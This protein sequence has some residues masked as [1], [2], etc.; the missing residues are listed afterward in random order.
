MF[1][2]GRPVRL[3]PVRLL[4]VAVG[5]ALLAGG[6]AG[7]PWSGPPPSTVSRNAPAGAPAACSPTVTISGFSDQL[8]KTEFDGRFV[9]N[10][11]GLAVDTDGN[12][13]A[14]SDRSLLFTLDARTHRPI[15]VRPLADEHGDQLDSEAVLV[16]RDGSRLITSEIEPSVRRYGAD[17]RLLG[18]LPVP[19]PLRVTPEGRASRNLT[20]EGLAA[21]PNGVIASMEAPLRD[22]QGNLVRF[23][24]WVRVGAQ[25]R[26]AAQYG[27][28]VDPGL[29]VSELTATGEGRLLVLE[30]GYLP[31]I[32]NTVR[33]YLADTR[34][35]SDVSGVAELRGAPGV[36]LV[37]RQLLADLGS[38]PSLGA[39]DRE[40]QRNPLL[41]N[42]EGMT[43]IGRD[44]TGSLR[45]LLVSDDNESRKQTTRLYTL[46]ARLPAP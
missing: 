31:G 15:A 11:S 13:L 29:G 39:T 34:S 23:Q 25:L 40:P 27:Y 37:R 30:R 6:C 1:A 5:V 3:V 4:I 9:G 10:L 41:D 2:Q 38:C 21:S 14:L 26:P 46:T 20:F 44:P 42:I 32:G 35:A 17:G 28:Q 43:I 22:D 7:A 45:L 19:A 18:Q 16:D 24:S 36:T 8:N 12:I 33:L